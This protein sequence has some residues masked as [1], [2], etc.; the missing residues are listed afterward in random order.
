M[1]MIVLC[2]CGH[3]FS[4]HTNDGCQSTRFVPCKCKLDSEGAIEAATAAVRS[5]SWDTVTERSTSDLHK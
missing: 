3:A 5:R 1:D 4:L 2:P